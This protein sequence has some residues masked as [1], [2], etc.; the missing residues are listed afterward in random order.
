M[1]KSTWPGS[2]RFIKIVEAMDKKVV[3]T[4]PQASASSNVERPPGCDTLFVG[5]L[6]PTADEK[7]IRKLFSSVGGISS[8]HIPLNEAG[9][10][11]GICYVTFAN[12]DHTVEGTK[13]AGTDLCGKPI[14]VDY[15]RPRE[16]KDAKG[17][18]GGN[19]E[20]QKK[21]K[22]ASKVRSQSRKK[23]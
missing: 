20:A 6:S 15:A 2:E 16:P 8:I 5:N 22:E 17:T 11:K 21:P 10:P 9:K 3:P 12:G 4:A 7:S 23:G 14:R 19:A 1:D 18:G 13:L